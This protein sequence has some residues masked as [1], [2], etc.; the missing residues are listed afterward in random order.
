ML[1]AMTASEVWPAG[2]SWADTVSVGCAVF[3]AATICLPHATSCALFEYQML[4]GP[5]ALAAVS[6]AGELP[7]PPHAA[8]VAASMKTVAME[9][10]VRD[11]IVVSSGGLAVAV[12]A[13]PRSKGVVCRSAPPVA[14]IARP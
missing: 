6:A 11:F 8:V 5:W 3:Q 12:A 10:S 14:S 7:P 4:I 13:M 2:I 1:A 9:G